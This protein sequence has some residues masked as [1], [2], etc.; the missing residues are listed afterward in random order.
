MCSG[1]LVVEANP[2]K[3][4][5]SGEF[6]FGWKQSYSTYEHK[7]SSNLREYT[8]ACTNIGSSFVR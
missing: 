2:V 3:Y 8:K 4:V 1:Y 6:I 7:K 5:W